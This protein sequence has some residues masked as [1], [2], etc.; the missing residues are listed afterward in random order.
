M[1]SALKNSLPRRAR[2]HGW[3]QDGQQLAPELGREEVQPRRGRLAESPDLWVGG[4][5]GF[6]GRVGRWVGRGGDG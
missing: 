5:V 2:L 6:G 4:R 1:I 3:E